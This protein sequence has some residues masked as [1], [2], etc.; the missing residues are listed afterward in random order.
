MIDPM[1][2]LSISTCLFKMTG[3]N[4]L[5]GVIAGTNIGRDTDTI[6]NLIG[7]LCCCMNGS[8]QIPEDWIEAVQE[9]NMDL[10]NKFKTNAREFAHLLEGKF[11][12]YKS[13]VDTFTRQ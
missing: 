5:E 13:I 6:A 11:N 9:I 4:Y 2:V 12:Q 7:G 3:G 1:E 10:Y 8:S